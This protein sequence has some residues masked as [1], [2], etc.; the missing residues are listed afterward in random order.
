MKPFWQQPLRVR[1]P[2]AA[3]QIQRRVALRRLL[4]TLPGSRRT[5]E[6]IEGDVARGALP[7]A[8][9]TRC[10]GAVA[11]A[12]AALGRTRARAAAALADPSRSRAREETAWNEVARAC[13]E[14][15]AGV[16]EVIAIRHGF[17]EDE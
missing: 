13:A 1:R 5:L 7:P 10:M 14:L 8:T 16:A 15:A 3:E 11:R 12:F 9:A 4:R 17:E 6:D 2:R